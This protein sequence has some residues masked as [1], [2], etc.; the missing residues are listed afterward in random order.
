MAVVCD[1]GGVYAL[2]DA[3]DAHHATVKV[4]VE[5]EPGALLLPTILLA[6]IDYLFNTRLGVD[7]TLDFLASVEA[8]AFTLVELMPKDLMR[9]RELVH[10]YRDLPLGLADASVIA[11]A[12]RLRLQRILTI[13]QRHFR[14]V[15]PSGFSHFILLPADFE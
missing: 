3:D 9:C 2:Y 5:S 12:E 1:T 13:D 15:N 11:I 6:E 7:A 8:G 14:T 4:V 10:Q